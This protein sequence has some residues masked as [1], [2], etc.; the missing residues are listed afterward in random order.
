MTRQIITPDVCCATGTSILST[1]E[2]VNRHGANHLTNAAA[3]AGLPETV[4]VHASAVFNPVKQLGDA[5]LDILNKYNEILASHEALKIEVLEMNKIDVAQLTRELDEAI[6]SD[7]RHQGVIQYLQGQV[8]AL[9]NE[10]NLALISNPPP[11]E[12]RQPEGSSGVLSAS[13]SAQRCSIIPDPPIFTDGKNSIVEHWLIKMRGKMEADADLMPTEALRMAYVQSRVGG[14][15]MNYLV[16]RMSKD[17]PKAFETAEEI[18]EYLERIFGDPYG[19]ENA[20]NKFRNLV[21]GEKDFATFWADFQHLLVGLDRDERTLISDLTW[22]LS[23]ETEQQLT[24]VDKRPT[25][26]LQYAERCRRVY[27]DI[28]N[29]KSLEEL[30]TYLLFRSERIINRCPVTSTENARLRKEDR[31]FVC[32]GQGHRAPKCLNFW[33]PMSSIV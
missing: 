26:L 9:Q 23:D 5:Y 1:V 4:N 21:Q 29:A 22:K 17:S 33:Q 19:Q 12:C 30:D 13:G 31:C 14:D 15:A 25:D 3:P 10:K 2:D 28:K 20:E 16:P 18:L 24:A 7:T 6:A 32:K 11:C 8:T 27:Q